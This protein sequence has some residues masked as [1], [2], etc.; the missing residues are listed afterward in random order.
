MP[1]AARS[2]LIAA[3]ALAD[4]M[5]SLAPAP[6]LAT[7]DGWEVPVA[8]ADDQALLPAVSSLHPTGIAAA[9]PAPMAAGR[10]VRRGI[11][12]SHWQRYIHW[13][14]VAGS[15]DFA[16]AKATEGRHIVDRW[17]RR[18]HARA[19]AA[20]VLFGAYHFASPGRGRKDAVRAADFFLRQA[21]LRPDDL[22]PALDLERTGD[23]GRHA[24][25]RWTLTWL[26]RVEARLGV[27]PI[28]YSNPDFWATEMG[29]TTVVAR[30][31]FELLWIGHWG[32]DAPTVPADRWAGEGWTF[33]QWTDCGSV[34]GITGCVDRDTFSG[35]RLHHL[36]IRHLRHGQAG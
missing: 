9:S 25:R 6:A 20:G 18:N 7:A 4:S 2:M 3:L 30:A 26:R 19:R 8:T 22:V 15:V 36:T 17:Y 13:P 11:D 34:E 27:R 23:L 12:V 32:A 1:P 33:W 21:R 29:D 35:P 24:L 28:L 10:G 31:G 16:F 14:V 5:V